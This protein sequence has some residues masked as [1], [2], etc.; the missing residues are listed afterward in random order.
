VPGRRG[1]FPEVRPG[2]GRR[3]EGDRA[4]TGRPRGLRTP[5]SGNR[6]HASPIA[7][8][9]PVSDQSELAASRQ[10]AGIEDSRPAR[11]D[12]PVVGPQKLSAS[13]GNLTDLGLFPAEPQ[14][15]LP[16]R[17]NPVSC[18]ASLLVARIKGSGRPCHDHAG[19]RRTHRHD[20]MAGG[21]ARFWLSMA[22][23]RCSSVPEPAHPE[24][25]NRKSAAAA[26]DVRLIFLPA[27]RGGVVA[28]AWSA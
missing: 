17:C 4:G 20:P 8:A 24:P 28:T 21:C 16:L 18:W 19:I 5:E 3:R 23:G 27:G 12:R 15:P 26:A 9:M 13:V 22:V 6:F 10:R 25:T 11:L 1:D 2:A 7:V 14:T